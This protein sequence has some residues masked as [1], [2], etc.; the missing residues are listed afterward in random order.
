MLYK[1]EECNIIRYYGVDVNQNLIYFKI[2]LTGKLHI[3]RDEADREGGLPHFFKCP[4]N[5]VK[6]T[7]ILVLAGKAEHHNIV[8]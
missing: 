8:L 4:G 6:I 1:G 2:F 5:E 7:E 3:H